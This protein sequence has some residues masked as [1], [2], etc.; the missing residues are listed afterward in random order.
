VI[1][2]HGEDARLPTLGVRNQGQVRRLVDAFAGDAWI[3]GQKG[4]MAQEIGGTYGG[5][6]SKS[7]KTCPAVQITPRTDLTSFHR[8]VLEISVF[9]INY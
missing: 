5:C 4:V 3:R 6:P 7:S 8:T 1:G 2:A 9:Y